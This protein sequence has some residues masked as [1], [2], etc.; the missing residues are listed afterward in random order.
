MDEAC[1]KNAESG[2]V[3]A[4]PPRLRRPLGLS[5]ASKQPPTARSPPPRTYAPLSAFIFHPAKLS[6]TRANG[7]SYEGIKYGA[8]KPY[9]QPLFRRRCAY[10]ISHE[11]VMGRYDAMEVDHFRPSSRSEFA[12]LK[13][14][15][16]N[17][18]YCCRVCNGRQGKSDHWPTEEQEAYGY[19]FVDPCA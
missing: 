6:H 19:R 11:D 3:G 4:L 16:T 14:E 8:Y 5:G 9:L 15:W 7:G 12:H 10:C 2:G 1:A 17:L 13:N 18:Y